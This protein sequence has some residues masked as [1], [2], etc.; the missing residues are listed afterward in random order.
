IDSARETFA[1]LSKRF[2]QRPEGAI[3]WAKA[4]G[5]IG[6]FSEACDA[7]N[8]L[9]KNHPGHIEGHC[10][11]GDIYAKSGRKKEALEEYQKTLLVNENYHPGILGVAAMSRVFGYKE[12]EYKALRKAL[13]TNSN[14]P[15]SLLR[16]GQLEREMR[17][18]SNLENFRKVVAL[19]PNS[20]L[21]EEAKY[22]LRHCD[23]TT[24]MAG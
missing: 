23:E 9:F 21:A 17:L 7:L 24:S 19:V 15:S 11:L 1:A 10:V 4:A 8:F 5:E 6:R 13:N 22:Y 2:P 16:L 14:D 18:P 3:K 20:V 12:E